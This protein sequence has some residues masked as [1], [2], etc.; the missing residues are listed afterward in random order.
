MDLAPGKSDLRFKWIFI[1]K[2]RCN[3]EIISKDG[4]S[5]FKQMAMVETAEQ[6][7]GIQSRRLIPLGFSQ[8]HLR[9]LSLSPSILFLWRWKYPAVPVPHLDFLHHWPIIPYV[10]YK[11]IFLNSQLTH[12]V[13]ILQCIFRCLLSLPGSDNVHTFENDLS[14][15]WRSATSFTT[16]P[17]TY[18]FN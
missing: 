16:N 3:L 8:L 6:G 7:E 12:D 10:Y 5:V 14:L 11:I 1:Q 4:S 17:D 18:S 9:G 2:H 15:L 13:L